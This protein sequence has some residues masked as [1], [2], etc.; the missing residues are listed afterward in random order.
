[1]FNTSTTIVL[2]LLWAIKAPFSTGPNGASSKLFFCV[3]FC[4]TI[5][6]VS[7]K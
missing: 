2:P 7:S 6:L 3:Y 5:A 4:L 1:M